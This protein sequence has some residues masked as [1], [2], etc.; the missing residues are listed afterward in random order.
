MIERPERDSG[1]VLAAAIAI[2]VVVHAA[3]IGLVNFDWPGRGL[4]DVPAS[5]DVV[6]VD[7]ATEETPE[8]PDFLAQVSQRGGGDSEVVERPAE[9]AANMPA[10]VLS[11]FE[12]PRQEAAEREPQEQVDELVAVDDDSAAPE[13]HEQMEDSDDAGL[14]AAELMSQSRSVARNSVEHLSEAVDYPSRP[15]R[16]FVS[17]ST[18]EHLY[19]SYMRS[20]VSKVERVGNMNY[21]EQARRQGL[22]GALVLSVDVLK[23]GSV[24]QIRLLKSSGYDVLDEAAIRIVRLSAPFAPLPEEIRREYDVLTITRTWQFSSSGVLRGS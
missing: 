3:V 13:L 23:D 7:W 16:K 17:A 1:D 21:P 5:L 4:A 6:L 22:A 8:D 11:A 18:R 2:T 9:S 24:N 10:D 20:W 19:A 14:S 12:Q 15:K